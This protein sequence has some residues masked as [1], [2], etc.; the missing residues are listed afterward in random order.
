M[1][2]R[3]KGSG[4]GFSAVTVNDHCCVG[5]YSECFSGMCVKIYIMI[6]IVM[7][8]GRLEGPVRDLCILKIYTRFSSHAVL[9]TVVVD[10]EIVCEL[11]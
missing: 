3:V 10:W 9:Y 5:I 6:V 1:G 11:I 4:V 8:W 2:L 7:H